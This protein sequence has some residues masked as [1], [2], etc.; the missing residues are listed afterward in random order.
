[1]SYIC[2]EFPPLKYPLLILIIVALYYKLSN[3]AK[4]PTQLF[5]ET[6]TTIELDAYSFAVVVFC[7]LSL[8]FFWMQLMSSQG[9]SF[10]TILAVI[11]M[12]NKSKSHAHIREILLSFN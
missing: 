9:S 2:Q 11:L 6:L 5:Q 12:G 8:F 3:F 10:I 1:M 7:F 4:I